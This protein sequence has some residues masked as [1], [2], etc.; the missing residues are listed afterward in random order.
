MVD[1]LIRC[2]ADINL[3]HKVWILERKVCVSYALSAQETAPELI[4]TH[5]ETID[6]TF[7]EIT[8][9]DIGFIEGKYGIC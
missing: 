4:T 1:I 7:E 5:L 6:P 8:Y 2:G 9:F 3:A